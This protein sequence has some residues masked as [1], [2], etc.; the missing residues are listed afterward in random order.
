V[1]FLPSAL[2]SSDKR[3]SDESFV[4]LYGENCSNCFGICETELTFT[5]APNKILSGYITAA[6]PV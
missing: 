6:A 3:D 5:G 4:K 1:N 2:N